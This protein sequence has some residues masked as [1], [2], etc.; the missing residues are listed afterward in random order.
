[1][2]KTVGLIATL[3][4]KG[5]EAEYIKGEIEKRGMSILLID[6]GTRGIPHVAGD[7]T[8]EEIAAAA[9]TTV[10]AIS[11]LGRGE[12][13]EKSQVGLKK[14]VKDLHGRG[15]LQ[16]LL[17][18]GGGD[19]ALLATAAMRVL[20]LGVPKM[21]VTP[22]AQGQERF[23]PYVGK[24]DITIMHSVIDILGVN[25]ISKK[26]FDLAVGAICGMVDVDLSF[27]EPTC[28]AVAVTMYGNTTPAV[29]VA[30]ALLEKRGIEVVTF[31]PNGTG[32]RAMEDL[33]EDGMFDGVLDM[34]THEI[35]DHLFKGHHAGDA[36]RLTAAG[37]K[38]V[39]Q[40]VV[41]GCVDFILGGP[42]DTLP[43]EYKARKTYF[44]NPAVTLVRTTTE[45]IVAVAG[46]MAAKL[47]RATGPTTLM[48]P[49]RGFS[50][51]AVPGGQMYDPDGDKAFIDAVTSKIDRGKV[52][53]VVV[54]AHINDPVFATQAVETLVG[55]MNPGG[56][57]TKWK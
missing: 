28:K 45:E 38:G 51:Y 56:E 6:S 47:N 35:T 50:M 48:I 36:D 10:A 49:R 12:A 39:P 1:M 14:I 42:I 16:G 17:S 4:T 54:D 19:G 52:D 2:R 18:I 31:H 3:D 37:K 7:V 57:G 43:P 25:R 53:V 30:K 22:I 26:I 8:R 55:M 44:F 27:G 29:M 21:L 40:L 33:V 32:G 11:A 20:P 15:K 23:G 34:T 13:N 41:P 46:V 9:G 24:S 5:P